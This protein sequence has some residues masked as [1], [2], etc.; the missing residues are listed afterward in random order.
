VAT[1]AA[2][3]HTTWIGPYDLTGDTSALELNLSHEPQECTPFGSV[4]MKRVA[5]LRDTETQVEGYWDVADDGVD[6][7]LFGQLAGLQV[8][9][10]TVSGTELDTAYTYQA[11]SYSY[12]FGGQ[13]GEVAPYTLQA[14]GARGNGT[15]SVG[16]IRGRLLK[17]KGDVSA[18]GALG[19]G[20]QLG[21]VGATQFLYGSFHIFSAGTTI[22]VVLESDDNS[23][24]TSATTRATLGPLTT[25][26]GTWATRVAG[27]ITDDYYRFRVTAI[28]GTF[29]VAG[30]AG[31]K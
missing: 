4:A 1:Y 27:A 22:T 13:V 8:V 2:L 9:T 7:T 20:Y 25:T 21:A 16:A 24:F 6:E 29:N 18:T 10:H 12:Q 14:Q 30:V 11:K 5:G 15:L 19:S 28:T 31:I 26:G 23:D 17:A 3:A